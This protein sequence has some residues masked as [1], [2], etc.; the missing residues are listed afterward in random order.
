MTLSD[1]I[2][3]Q[4]HPWIVAGLIA[5]LAAG[6]ALLAHVIVIPL[7]R[8]ALA[9]NLLASTV[10][11]HVTH[12]TRY[13]FPLLAL[14]LVW[15]ASPQNLAHL[16]GVRLFTGVLLTL[17]FTWVM[18]RA[19][20]GI[21]EAVVRLHPSHDVN[22]IQ[23]RRVKTQTRVLSR[24]AAFFVLVIGFAFALM[25]FPGARH[26]GASLL[27]S[28]GLAGL[29]AGIAARSVL[30]NLLAGLQIALSQP[31]R[32]D[33]QVVIEGEWGTI[34]EITS[35]YVVVAIWD[36]RR[37]IVPLQ[38]VIEHPFQNWTRTASQLLGTVTFWVDYTTALAPLRAELERVCAAA[39]EWDHRLALLQVVD[40]SDRA[41]QVRC[42]VS[43]AD[44]GKTWDLRCRVRE[45]MIDFVQRTQPGSLPRIRSDIELSQRAQGADPVRA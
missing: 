28:A 42:L 5:L 23:S 44:A 13:L 32:I 31:L 33:D 27:A 9:F 12:S 40:A 37:L 19:V 6:L 17:V 14:E 43:A 26:I 8:R 22:D 34:E 3:T 4:T 11:D 2:P 15:G 38:W 16:Q 10:L 36:Q 1:F 29:A 41:I 20:Q 39:P 25:L 24:T 45:A 7:L 18:M 30:S 35:T 21:A